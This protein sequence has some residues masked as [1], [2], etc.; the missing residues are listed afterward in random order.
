MS[1][2][3]G[4]LRMCVADIHHVVASHAHARRIVSINLQSD[5]SDILSQHLPHRAN[6]DVLSIYRYGN[7]WR[8]ARRIFH[9]FFN[10]NTT[11]QYQPRQIKSVHELLYRI[12]HAADDYR[13]HIRLC[14]TSR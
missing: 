2:S 14:V 6:L 7:K 10:S 11:V 12:S 13:D 5:D 3:M 4:V 1:C 8:T 9:H